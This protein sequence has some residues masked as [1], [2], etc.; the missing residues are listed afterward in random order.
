M[1]PE[2]T[3]GELR[4]DPPPRP[5]EA[6]HAGY[7]ELDGGLPAYVA[8]MRARDEALLPVDRHANAPRRDGVRRVKYFDHRKGKKKGKGAEAADDG[9]LFDEDDKNGNADDAAKWTVLEKPAP[10]N[11]APV[12]VDGAGGGANAEERTVRPTRPAVL[13]KGRAAAEAKKKNYPYGPCTF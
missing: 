2:S 10:Q 4:R 6:L 13:L 9:I 11:T 5:A 3:P 8:G 1:P 12:A 7:F